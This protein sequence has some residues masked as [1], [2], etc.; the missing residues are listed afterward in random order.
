MAGH[1]NNKQ[2]L[3]LGS[4]GG[5]EGCWSPSDTAR[6]LGANV[7]SNGACGQLSAP[8]DPSQGHASDVFCAN[9]RDR[10]C[11]DQTIAYCKANGY[12]KF[13]NPPPPPTAQVSEV[14]ATS[15]CKSAADCG[16]DGD[17]GGY[18]KANGDCHCTAPFFASDGSTCKL[19]CT[20]TSKTPCCRDNNDCTKDGDK[21]AY[22]KSPRSNLHTT[23]GNGMCRCGIGFSGTTSCHKT[24]EAL[25]APSQC[26]GT[27][28][29]FCTG[30]VVNTTG[31][32]CKGN[33]CKYW[34]TGAG[35][36]CQGCYNCKCASGGPG[37]V[38]DPRK[39]KDSA[40]NICPSEYEC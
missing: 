10:N 19:T 37:A 9:Y 17:M 27:G 18:C 11:P 14:N 38:D 5:T 30:S 15:G 21:A 39:C 4:C 12:C 16:A 29:T 1:T 23:P 31:S 34:A 13:R 2:V 25:E 22:C 20:P 32:C 3:G 7:T 40:G 24:S 35:K 33:F 28:S 8:C 36:V 6:V 26:G